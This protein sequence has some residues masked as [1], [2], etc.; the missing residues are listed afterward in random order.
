MGTRP[1]LRSW[2]IWWHNPTPLAQGPALGS[3][4]FWT[5]GGTPCGCKGVGGMQPCGPLYA[6]ALGKACGPAAVL[7]AVLGP[8]AT[9]VTR[10]AS[11]VNHAPSPGALNAPGYVQG[12][13]AGQP[14]HPL[15]TRATRCGQCGPSPLTPRHTHRVNVNVNVNE[16]RLGF[17]NTTRNPEGILSHNNRKS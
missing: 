12:S 1:T 17:S 11:L 9:R 8:A 2:R 7:G 6:T 16:L 10:P 3:M 14:D 15:E 4:S 13:A 5:T